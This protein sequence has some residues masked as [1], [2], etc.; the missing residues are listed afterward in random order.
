MFINITTNVNFELKYNINEINAVSHCY[1]R[2][3][4]LLRHNYAISAYHH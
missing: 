3:F 4:I 2:L 1:L